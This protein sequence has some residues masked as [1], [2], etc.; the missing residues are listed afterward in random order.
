MQWLETV[1]SLPNLHPALVHFPIVLLMLAAALDAGSVLVRRWSSW[2]SL[3]SITYLLGGLAAWITY[4]SGRSA[5]D[6]LGM[7]PA[8][9]QS[10]LARHADLGWW[11]VAVATAVALLKALQLGGLGLSSLT[12]HP[13]FRFATFAAG[14]A[15][16]ALVGLTADRGGALVYQ[17][18]LAVATV[19]SPSGSSP[20]SS[21][22]QAAGE[23]GVMIDDDGTLEWMPGIGASLEGALELADPAT[24]SN[25]R[26]VA[27]DP[28][29]GV[30]LEA[31]GR[32]ILLFAPQYGDLQAELRLDLSGFRG[33]V[34]L[35]HQFSSVES[36]GA[37][38][39]D[40]AAGQASLQEVQGGTTNSLDQQPFDVPLDETVTLAVSCAGSHRKGFANGDLVVHGHTDA[41]PPGP[42]GLLI[43][44]EGQIRILEAAIFPL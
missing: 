17:H 12:K 10:A 3:A 36:Y 18:G 14:L 40:T 37:F 7:V 32:S 41:R 35:L 21:G 33:K 9:A 19:E 30:L 5:A 1:S 39:V 38:V 29:A 44:G 42:V 43:D 24:A 6:G 16:V 34:A 15:G 20:E 22:Q 13:A 23:T 11:V 27:G 26:V 28:G 4:F 8:A 31:G 25:L 2:N